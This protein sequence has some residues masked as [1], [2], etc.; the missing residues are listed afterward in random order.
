MVQKALMAR[1]YCSRAESETSSSPLGGGAAAG[2]DDVVNSAGPRLPGRARRPYGRR[3]RRLSL[4]FA[5]SACSTPDDQ[6]AGEAA[7]IKLGRLRLSVA[8][9][10]RF[11]HGAFDP[12]GGVA[13]I[14]AHDPLT[15][16]LLVVNGQTNAIDV[17]D[18]SDPSALA[19]AAT[20]DLSGYGGG[21][22]S[23]ATHA[24]VAAAA[25]Q[26]PVSTDPGSIVFFDVATGGVLDVVEAGALPDMVEFT[27]DGRYLLSADEGESSPDY[28][29]DPE[30]SVTVVDLRAGFPATARRA[31]FAAFDG[32][33]PAGVRIGRPGAPAS[34]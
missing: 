20:V 24:G 15:Q 10:G 13:E 32:A 34:R 7:E 4:L 3:M 23:V 26:G 14:V 12:D 22:Q 30:G 1:R 9:I 28:S 29:V 2:G 33:V 5:L 17:L 11:A 25:V 31:T 8:P 6:V 19:L 18:M 27:R 21:V 16:R